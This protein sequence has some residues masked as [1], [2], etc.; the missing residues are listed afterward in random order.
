MYVLTAVIRFIVVTLPVEI[1]RLVR[2]FLYRLCWVAGSRLSGI[3][4]VLF[5]IASALAG[6]PNPEWPVHAIMWGGM[7]MIARAAVHTVRPGPRHQRP[8]KAANP[9]QPV[10][11]MPARLKNRHMRSDYAAKVASLPEEVRQIVLEGVQALDQ[12]SQK[13]KTGYSLPTTHISR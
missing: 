9:F 11:V 3:G 12:L 10:H 6:N 2:F 7:V 1:V 13:H 4:L 5:I 8:G